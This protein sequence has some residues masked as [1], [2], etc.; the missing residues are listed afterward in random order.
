[1]TSTRSGG[2]RDGVHCPVHRALAQIAAAS[3]TLFQRLPVLLAG[4]AGALQVVP[5]HGAPDGSPQVEHADIVLPRKA[6]DPLEAYLVIWNPS[7]RYRTL[8]DVESPM[9]GGFSL[10]SGV[11]AHASLKRGSMEA[12]SIPPRAELLMKRTGLHMEMTATGSAPEPGAKIFLTLVFGDGER[13]RVTADV[14]AAGVEL[15]DHHHGEA[16]AD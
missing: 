16:R 9:I 12:L 11:G 15:E 7:S 13:R 5:A 8:V 4:L 2:P 6:G 10:V 3:G 14:R 1:M